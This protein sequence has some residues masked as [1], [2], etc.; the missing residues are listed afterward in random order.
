MLFIGG[1]HMRARSQ[2]SQGN[3]HSRLK[4]AW[5]ALAAASLSGLA[6]LG[7][8]SDNPVG[9]PGTQAV[10]LEPRFGIVGGTAHKVFVCVDIL[11]DP[12]PLAGGKYAFS[13]EIGRAS[14]R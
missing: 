10:T 11:S 14:C 13:V 5:V 4:A 12:G 8:C 3:S 7:A 2:G 1:S 9:S 6:V